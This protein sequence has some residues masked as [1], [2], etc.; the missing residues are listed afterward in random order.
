[1]E[2]NVGKEIA[3]LK[4]MTV[5]ELRERYAEVFSEE[6]QARNKQGLVKRV[7]WRLQAMSEGSC[8]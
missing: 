6:T 5:G 2:L 3:A 8:Q 7:I 1:M 4:R